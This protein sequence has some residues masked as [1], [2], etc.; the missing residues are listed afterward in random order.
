MNKYKPNNIQITIHIII[1]VKNNKEGIIKTII[2]INPIN[3]KDIQ[4][5]RTFKQESH[6]N[7]PSFSVTM[8]HSIK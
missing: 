8:F 4:T 7:R 5:R 1:I 3:K 2:K 6:N